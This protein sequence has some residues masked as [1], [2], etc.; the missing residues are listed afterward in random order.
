MKIVRF[1][2]RD[3]LCGYM[4]TLRRLSVEKNGKL[5]NGGYLSRIRKF[6][7]VFDDVYRNFSA[8]QR[9][10]SLRKLAELVKMTRINFSAE[11][12]LICQDQFLTQDY[13]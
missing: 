5:H 8:N 7:G 4:A 11:E 12:F 13:C 10:E 9:A 6:V 3:R 2:H 1:G